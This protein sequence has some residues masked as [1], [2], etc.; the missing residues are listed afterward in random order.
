EA[1]AGKEGQDAE[2]A[3]LD[4]AVCDPA[5][6]SAHFLVAAAHRM[7]KYVAMARTG[8]PEPAPMV[9]QQALRDVVSRCLYGVDVNP[10]AVELAKVSLWLECHVPGQ[11]LTFLDH[12]IKC[13][14]S[15]IGVDVPDLIDWNPRASEAAE[16]K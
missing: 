12:H 11:P 10:M 14:N 9:T 7:A 5:C 4:L 1:I 8:D 3:L 15:L 2:R 13:G 16:Q 6:G